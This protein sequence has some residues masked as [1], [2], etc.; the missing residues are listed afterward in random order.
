MPKDRFIAS[1]FP[2]VRVNELERRELLHIVDMHVE[3]Y[4]T[5]Y[6]DHVLVDKRKV[7]NRRWEHVKSKDKLRV[8]AERT[9]KELSRRG[10]E[11]ETSLSA[12]QRV[13]EHSVS[14]DLPVVMGIGTLVGDLDDLMFGVVSPTLDDM[15]VKASYVHDVDSAAV[16]CPVVGPSKEDPFRSVVIKWMAIDVPLQSTNLVRS[17]DFVYVE[18]TGTAFLPTGDRVGYHL[19]HS[20]DFPQTKPLPKK[21]RG[22]LSVFSCFRKKR[23]FIVENF[24]WGVVDPGGDIMR[25]LA[26][27]VAAGALLSAT[28]YVHCGQMKKLTWMLQHHA[29]LER[30]RTAQKKQ[31]VVC[32]KRTSSALGS[33]GKSTCRICDGCV[34]HSCKIRHRIN[35][36][37]PGGQLVQRKVVVC[38]KCMKEAT[39]W[40][41][42]EAARDEAIRH[43]T[44]SA[45]FSFMDTSESS[46]DENR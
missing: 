45:S 8:Y 13:Q 39:H 2:V 12:T 5:K 14:K 36:I 3:D 18:A 46:Y 9:H 6:V 17:R 43:E 21:T 34:C 22:S 7:D 16:L 10:I 32:D 15:R 11:P 19:M 42:Q 41:A 23:G 20:I 25:S 31:C 40:N 44:T 38:A 24:A 29:S 30:Q 37:A 26:V 35:F 27:S 4:I 33:L 28:N 1:P